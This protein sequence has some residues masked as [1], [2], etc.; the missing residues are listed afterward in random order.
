MV[1][2]AD[3]GVAWPWSVQPLHFLDGQPHR[4]SRLQRNL[5]NRLL[6]PTAGPGGVAMADHGLRTLAPPPQPGGV[7]EHGRWLAHVIVQVQ[8]T[9]LTAGQV[10][11]S[12]RGVPVKGGR[13]GKWCRGVS[14]E[15]VWGGAS[16]V[17]VTK[18]SGPQCLGILRLVGVA[19]GSQREWGLSGKA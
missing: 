8:W 18:W 6:E 17:G 7:V 14:G 1:G 4:R 3:A 16:R 12:G 5:F 13:F 9:A 10:E 11:L 19:R 15:R 2:T